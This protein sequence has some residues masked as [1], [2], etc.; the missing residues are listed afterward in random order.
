MQL[1]TGYMLVEQEYY[2]QAN[3]RNFNIPL[4]KEKGSIN[5]T[6]SA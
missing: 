4:K 1:N 2:E 5:I 3:K 6:P